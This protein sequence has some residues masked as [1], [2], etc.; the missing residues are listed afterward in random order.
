VALVESHKK[1]IEV[2]PIAGYSTSVIDKYG[3]YSYLF[4]DSGEHAGEVLKK[5]TEMIEDAM[6]QGGIVC[7]HDIGNQFTQQKDALEYLVSTGKYEWVDINWQEI[8]NYVSVNNLEEGN[9]SW[10]IYPE[11]PF[12]NF[13]GALMRK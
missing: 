7:S 4:W 12:P 2:V 11:N 5:E 3:P 9:N 1:Q 8:V 10:H 6:A 13:V